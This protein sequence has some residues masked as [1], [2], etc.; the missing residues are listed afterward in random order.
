MGFTPSIVHPATRLR[1]LLARE[2]SLFMPGCYDALSARLIEISG[3]AVEASLLGRPDIGL[4]TMT[5]MADHARRITNAVD[6]PIIADVDTGFGGVQNIFRTIRAMEQAGL[7]G[8]HL[9]DQKLPRSAPFCQDSR[10]YRSRSE[11]SLCSGNRG[12]HP[13]GLHHHR[14]YRCR[15]DFL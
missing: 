8:L 2:Q 3:F 10:S 14:P 13:C 11:R 4:I 1:Q 5:E 9:E 12:A 7:A 15:R 6:L